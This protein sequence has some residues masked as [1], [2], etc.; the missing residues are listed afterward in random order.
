VRPI[1]GQHVLVANPGIETFFV[2]APV[3]PSWAAYLPHGDRVV[4]GGV[5][6][7]DA[8][9]TEPDPATAEGI[10][11]RCAAIEPRLESAEVVGHV[12]GLRPGRPTVRLEAE[13]IGA[14]RC[15]HNYGHGGSGVALSWGTARAAAALLTR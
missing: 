7:E 4:L 2:E 1:R 10:L 12:A 8:W 3:G 5:A 9:S 13:R 6:E 15:V 11:R 14:A